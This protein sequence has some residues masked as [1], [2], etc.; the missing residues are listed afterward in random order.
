MKPHVIIFH[1]NKGNQQWRQEREEGEVG[2][3]ELRKVMREFIHRGSPKT[4]WWAVMNDKERQQG[5]QAQEMTMVFLE[6]ET[7]EPNPTLFFAKQGLVHLE[8]LLLKKKHTLGAD[9]ELEVT[10][11]AQTSASQTSIRAER[12]ATKASRTVLS[13]H[14]LPPSSSLLKSDSMWTLAAFNTLLCVV[15]QE[16]HGPPFRGDSS[17]RLFP[18]FLE[19]PPVPGFAESSLLVLG[20]VFE[21]QFPSQH[22][23]R[24]P[25]N[26]QRHPAV[27]LEP[28]MDVWAVAARGSVDE[29]RRFRKRGEAILQQPDEHGRVALHYAAM[30]GRLSMVKYLCKHH[31][32]IDARDS[33]D[34]TVL[35]F[36]EFVT[37]VPL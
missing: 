30:N 5:A 35:I 4:L 10:R 16:V 31:A 1:Y 3:G 23:S 8:G 26:V 17:P 2:S 21:L 34:S 29:I 25:S 9:N 6:D 32:L 18:V 12:A 37:F 19:D 14:P 22:S 20:S 15:D 13:D 27:A 28:L 36:A 24:R 7:G 11:I 33:N